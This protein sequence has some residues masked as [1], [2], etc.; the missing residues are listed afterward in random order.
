MAFIR[1]QLVDAAGVVARDSDD[2]VTWRVVSGL[3]QASWAQ[4]SAT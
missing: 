1:V 2:N 3:T 4:W